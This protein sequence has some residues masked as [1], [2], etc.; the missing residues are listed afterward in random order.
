MDLHRHPDQAFAFSGKAAQTSLMNKLCRPVKNAAIKT[1]A[2]A[3][4][5]EH[6]EDADHK[7]LTIGLR[8]LLFG[9]RTPGF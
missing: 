5:H 2:V 8:A 7:A 6:R 4:L 3:Y 1:D 9:I